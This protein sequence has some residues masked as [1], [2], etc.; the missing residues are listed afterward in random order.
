MLQRMPITYGRYLETD[1]E[2]LVVSARADTGPTPTYQNRK[3]DDD[4]SCTP[5]GFSLP[6]TENEDKGQSPCPY[7]ICKCLRSTGIDSASLCSLADQYDKQ[8]GPT[9]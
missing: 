4:L 5:L 9:C 6:H 2:G 7:S 3:Y 1:A 8:G